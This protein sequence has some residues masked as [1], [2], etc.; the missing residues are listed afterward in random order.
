MTYAAFIRQD[1]R[2]RILGGRGLPA[3][4]TLRGLSRDYGVSLTPVRQAVG[5][6]LREAL[7]RKEPN[8]RLAVNPGRARA[9]A[10]R[11]GRIAPPGQGERRIA[12]EVMKLSLQGKEDFLREETTARRYGVGRTQLRHVF[13]RLVAAGLLEHVP[14]RGWRVRAFREEEADAYLEVRELLELK[15]LDLARGRLDRAELAAILA[16]NR[17]SGP[18][19][20]VDDRLHAYLIEKSGNRYIQD[21]FRRHG[22]YFTTLFYFAALGAALVADMAAQHRRILKA[23]LRGAWRAARR[24]LARH[25]RAQRPVVRRM[26]ERLASLPASKWPEV[27]SPLG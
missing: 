12:R 3:R 7:L 14:R 22:A 1:L 2:A 24:E 4:L 17:E 15:A 16:E 10:V 27:P 25:I 11:P 13:A 18:A 6:L 21:F 20:H 8:G 9:K 26:M 23:L 19:P 5:R